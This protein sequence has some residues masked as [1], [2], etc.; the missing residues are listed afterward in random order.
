MYQILDLYG[1]IFEELLAIPVVRGHKTEKEKFAGAEV[2]TT[3]EAYVPATGRGVQ[4][5]TSHYLGQNFSRIFDIQFEHPDTKQMEFV[6]QNSWGITTRTIG[7]LTMI[8]GDER[9]MPTFAPF[10]PPTHAVLPS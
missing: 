4:G 7:I 3:V 5:A 10:T 2:T 6:H 9:G 8:H 1:R